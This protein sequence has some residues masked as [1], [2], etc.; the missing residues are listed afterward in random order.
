MSS[1]GTGIIYDDE[2]IPRPSLRQRIV[3]E[4]TPVQPQFVVGVSVTGEKR[5]SEEL[6]STGTALI[7]VAHALSD[8]APVRKSISFSMLL[9]FILGKFNT[10]TEY[11]KLMRNVNCVE[12][13]PLLLLILAFTIV[14]G[15]TVMAR[16][17]ALFCTILLT[18]MYAKIL[19]GILSIVVYVVSIW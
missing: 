4:P 11:E 1:I 7:A 17:G 10:I 19:Y 2:E 16:I 15:K 14:N 8:T 5:Y 12:W 3:T 13:V 18:L 9:P 6:S